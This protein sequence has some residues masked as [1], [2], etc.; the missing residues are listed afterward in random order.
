[1]EIGGGGN[2]SGGLIV[3]SGVLQLDTASA[4]G[5]SNNP[6]TIGGNPLSVGVLGIAYNPASQAALNITSGSSGVLA[7]TSNNVPFTA[8]LNMATLGNGSMFLGAEGLGYAASLS[9]GT[10][11]G[12]TLGVG[13]NG[14][15]GS[16]AAATRLPS[17]IAFS[18]PAPISL[19]AKSAAL[20]PLRAATHTV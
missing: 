14:P 11:A 19:S 7:L 20:T 13:A 15:I 6:I 4:A 18:P 2:F 3:S 12:A 16:V 1:M 17:P 5:A 8:D 9:T 10:Y